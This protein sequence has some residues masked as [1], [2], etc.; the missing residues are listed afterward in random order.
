MGRLATTLNHLSVTP[1][2]HT[3]HAEPSDTQSCP[4]ALTFSPTYF[5][6]FAATAI[7]IPLSS[8]PTNVSCQWYRILVFTIIATNHFNVFKGECVCTP[9]GNTCVFRQQFRPMRV[10]SV[11]FV[12]FEVQVPPFVCTAVQDA[13]AGGQARRLLIRNNR[14]LLAASEEGV[15]RNQRST[16]TSKNNSRWTRP[17]RGRNQ[18][19]HTVP[20][21]QKVLRVFP[22]LY[23]LCLCQTRKEKNLS[24]RR[25]GGGIRNDFA[26][27]CK[28]VEIKASG[29]RGGSTSTSS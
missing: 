8:D 12:C 2:S 7:A 4:A 25:V 9:F 29:E 24:E 11:H 22:Q 27:C 21:P 1:E 19:S 23:S 28:D 18:T 10:V 13:I 20:I 26:L 5:T 14:D 15:A 6:P 16:T 17:L 3:Q